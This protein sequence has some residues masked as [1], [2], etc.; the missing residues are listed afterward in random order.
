MRGSSAPSAG[1]PIAIIVAPSPA[2]AAG[3]KLAPMP[4]YVETSGSAG[5]KE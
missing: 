4:A 3:A 1:T 2:D 5:L